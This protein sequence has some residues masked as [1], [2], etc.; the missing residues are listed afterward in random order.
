[1]SPLELAAQLC[2]VGCSR[3]SERGTIVLGD[4]CQSTKWWPYQV[5]WPG[6]KKGKKQKT[7]QRQHV[8]DSHTIFIA[9][10]P[11]QVQS[12][13]FVLSWAPE[14]VVCLDREDVSYEKYISQYSVAAEI[15]GGNLRSISLN[16]Q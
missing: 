9:D 12:F 13:F 6:G 14:E 15:D 16:S 2:K 10:G 1:M 11:K 5:K 4:S 3:Q 7:K 8:G